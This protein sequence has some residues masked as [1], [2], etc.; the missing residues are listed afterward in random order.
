MF[1]LGVAHEGV[2]WHACPSIHSPRMVVDEATLPRGAA[3]LAGCA[4][5]FLQAGWTAG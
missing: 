5:R 3:L 4:L 2:D 1:F